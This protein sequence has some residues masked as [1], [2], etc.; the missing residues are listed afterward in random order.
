MSRPSMS[1]PVPGSFQASFDDLGR[2]LSET[3]FVVVD[4]ETTGGAPADAGI[5]E[6]GAVKV[7]G[8][9]VL[10]EFQTLVRPESSIPAF[11]QVL[12][13][14]TNSMVARAPR[15][16]QVLPSFLEFAH[17]AVLV[18]HNAPYD[19]SFLAGAC[20]RLGLTWP[21]PEVV[22]TVVLARLLVSQDE[23]PNRKLGTLAR[24]FG[25][26]TTPDHR[27]LNDARATVDVLH[28]LLGRLG[29]R[30]IQTMEDLTS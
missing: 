2:L 9:D 20:R 30:G 11:V 6:I 10:G 16:A 13:G 22:D 12:T 4:L 5:T 27:A 19:T 26:Q 24:L 15:A 29:N 23:A 3:T 1:H 7:R 28:A 18:A 25:A 14:I 8:G 17:G 21:K